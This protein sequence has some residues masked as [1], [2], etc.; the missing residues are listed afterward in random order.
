[1]LWEDV[2]SATRE[3]SVRAG[4]CSL[5]VEPLPQDATTHCTCHVYVVVYALHVVVGSIDR[6]VEPPVEGVAL[7]V[8]AHAPC[9]ACSV[10]MHIPSA[11]HSITPCRPSASGVACSSRYAVYH[12]QGVECIR[13]ASPTICIACRVHR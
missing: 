3:P 2:Y 1:M 8:Y 5:R 11:V 10:C 9:I 12:L 7:G 6:V 4:I 13:P